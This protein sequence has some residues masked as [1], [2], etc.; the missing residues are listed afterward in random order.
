MWLRPTHGPR[1]AF[2]RAFNRVY[3]VVERGY[4]R[5]I[6]GMVA[7]P[8]QMMLLFAALIVATMVG[9]AHLPTG[10]LPVEDQGYV[11]AGAQLP[12]A[13]S[14]P[15]M[16]A[17]V[18][19]INR[20]IQDTPGVADWV[21]IGGNSVLDGTTASNAATFYIVFKPWEERTTPSLSQDAIVATL[22][23]RLAQIQE[24][25][26]FVFP[27]PSIRGLGVSGG[28][29]MQLEDRGGVGLA[30]LQQMVQE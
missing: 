6:A 15:R 2:F 3:G 18:D 4:A 30:A 23:K 9:F 11:I 24:G 26:T 5:L 16:S 13:A 22:R 8:L 7:R 19:Q 25:I 28:F 12:D 1:N 10:F 14:Q 21:T 29:Q 17:V 20:I 27:P